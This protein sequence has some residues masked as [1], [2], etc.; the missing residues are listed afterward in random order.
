M[1]KKLLIGVA[2]LGLLLVALIAAFNWWLYSMKL[3]SKDY[4]SVE[5]RMSKL[6]QNMHISDVEKSKYCYHYQDG[7]GDSKEL[8]CSINMAGYVDAKSDDGLTAI[9][10]DFARHLRTLSK[11]DNIWNRQD[12]PYA[13]EGPFRS[14]VLSVKDSKITMGC[15]VY[16]KAASDT[17]DVD[18]RLP[19][20]N[21]TGKAI[22]I[23]S[24]G[25]SSRE[26]YFEMH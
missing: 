5:Q 13:Y 22:L 7:V 24:C 1:R 17:R 19:E 8:K 16:V 10:E 14:G 9:A 2:T 23:L 26:A 3:S 25:G 4:T 11:S 21:V 12:G 20:R 6:Y 15:L 18:S